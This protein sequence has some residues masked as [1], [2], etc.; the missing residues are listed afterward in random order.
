MPCLGAPPPGGFPL[1][2]PPLAQALTGS[3]GAAILA[4][5]GIALAAADLWRHFR[6]SHA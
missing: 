5:G 2:P 3:L 4:L 1:L 6:A